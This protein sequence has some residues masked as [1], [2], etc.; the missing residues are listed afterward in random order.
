M[1]ELQFSG[2]APPVPVVTGV[3]S[4]A[5]TLANFVD[6]LPPAQDVVVTGQCSRGS[7]PSERVAAQLHVV[8]NGTTADAAPI[9]VLLFDN[10]TSCTL[11]SPLSFAMSNFIL[12]APSSGSGAPTLRS[13]GAL[14]STIGSDG[15][16]SHWSSGYSGASSTVPLVKSLSNADVQLRVVGVTPDGQG[17]LSAVQLEVSLDGVGLVAGDVLRIQFDDTQYRRDAMMRHPWPNGT[18]R[19]A[20]CNTTSN[21]AAAQWGGTQLTVRFTSVSCVPPARRYGLRVDGFYLPAALGVGF[22]TFVRTLR[23]ERGGVTVVGAADVTSVAL[24]A[25][26]AACS[27]NGVCSGAGCTCF[28]GYG[29]PS[30]AVCSLSSQSAQCVF[31]CDGSVPIPQFPPRYVT[32]RDKCLAAGG[33]LD[34]Q[35]QCHCYCNGSLCYYT[36]STSLSET[37]TYSATSTEQLSASSTPSRSRSHHSSLSMTDL[38]TSTRLASIDGSLS[39]SFSQSATRGRSDTPPSGSRTTP[40]NRTSS[41]TQTLEP[42][43]TISSTL[44]A[45]LQDYFTHSLTPTC[46]DS[47]SVEPIYTPSSMDPWSSRCQSRVSAK[48]R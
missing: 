23:L 47:D 31:A 3:V 21:A 13:Y 24:E 11:T 46:Y 30:C 48:K 33:F 25:A 4:S 32:W 29:G 36:S 6:V 44:T 28:V 16:V 1:Y 8:L 45:H 42:T 5:A 40:P 19:L 14:V 2:F 22:F 7:T 43:L 35:H 18:V 26:C 10:L 39:F 12:V 15:A 27:W 9:V 37:L 41:S 38:I 20:G 34:P 17:T